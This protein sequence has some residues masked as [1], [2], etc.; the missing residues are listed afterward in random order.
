MATAATPTTAYKPRIAVAMVGIET[1]PNTRATMTVSGNAIPIKSGSLDVVW[2]TTNTNEVIESPR[3]GV[4][5]GQPTSQRC[6]GSFETYAYG[7]G[8]DGSTNPNGNRLL[9]NVLQTCFDVTV[10]G[11]GHTRTATPT[12]STPLFTAA[13]STITAKGKTFSLAGYVGSRGRT[14]VAAAGSERLFAV[15]TGCS[16]SK[17]TVTETVGDLTRIKVEFVGVADTT[18]PYLKAVQADLDGFAVDAVPFQFVTAN[19]GLLLEGDST[20]PLYV[21]KREVTFD[22]GAEH[23]VSDSD[24]FGVGG[25]TTGD[26]AV[27]GVIDPLTQSYDFDLASYSGTVVQIVPTNASYPA[28]GTTAGYGFKMEIPAALVTVKTNRGGKVSRTDV[29]FT[30]GK[31]TAETDAIARLVW[32]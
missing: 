3:G 15:L 1:T 13:D 29:A 25:T 7:S 5:L 6:S 2:D 10:N 26:I 9:T 22:F 16:V 30:A 11:T 20:T 27:T 28:T 19:A 18:D 32:V 23:V 31:Y 21:T 4:Y 8:V 17:V 24:R 14:D 12:I